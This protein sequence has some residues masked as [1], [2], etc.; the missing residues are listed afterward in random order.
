M[1][2]AQAIL[3]ELVAR[4]KVSQP[5]P[6]KEILEVLIELAQVVRDLQE[7]IYRDRSSEVL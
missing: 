6:E 5:L 1:K 7:G 2:T 3:N 4:R